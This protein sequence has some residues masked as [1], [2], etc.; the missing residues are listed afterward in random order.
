MGLQRVRHDRATKHIHET[1][2][3]LHRVREIKDRYASPK[4]D[5]SS[6]LQRSAPGA[7]THSPAHSVDHNP[8]LLGNHWVTINTMHGLTLAEKH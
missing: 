1:T 2:Q 7:Q 4:K 5:E 6:V 3:G 8:W